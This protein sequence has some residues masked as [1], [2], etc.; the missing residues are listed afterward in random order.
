MRRL[1]GRE[2]TTL[3][4]LEPELR[5][6]WVDALVATGGSQC[7]FCTPGILLRLAA[8]TSTPEQALLAHLCRCTGWQTITE[9]AALVADGTPTPAAA[10]DVE[11]AS[12]R[13]ELE[14][15][16]AQRVGP[17]VVCGRGGFA[18]DG[19]PADAYVAVPRA[20]G[21][22]AVGATLAEARQAA[23]KVQ[24]RSTTLQ[25]EPPL[26]V[27]EGPWVATLATSWVEPAYL[28]PDASWCV[29]GGEPASPVG[30]GG[31]FGAKMATPVAE[32][33]RALADEYG[34]PV[35]VVWAREDVVRLGHK[36][37]PVAGGIAADGTGLLLVGWSGPPPEPA[38]WAAMESL[39]GAV[40]PGLV[41]ERV[42]ILGPPTSLRLRATV[43][44]EAA[45]LAGALG[46]EQG[47]CVVALPAR[48]QA[49]VTLD[50]ESVRVRVRAGAELDATV[51]RSYVI[52]A[53]HQGLGW[54]RS[55]G[56]AVEDDGTVRDLTIR[57]YGILAA[58]AMPRVD[59]EIVDEPDRPPVAVSD[60]VYVATALAAWNEA[61]RPTSWPVDRGRR[62]AP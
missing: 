61:G 31:A 22:Y 55:E 37:P 39:V 17:E 43:V 12:R 50:G 4:G 21:G 20:S 62:V 30:N 45:V 15:G 56:I 7:G 5:D 60:S 41:L 48:G 33:A 23:G 36:R 53:V 46:P 26:A 27:P 13:A 28:E 38:E 42:S 18:D 3:D 24:G 54:V 44:A 10:R 25:P 34:R 52:G 51:L 2:I 8:A 47:A 11:G 6:R 14:G 59:V 49:E 58:R 16:I 35:R 1:D 9:A 57:S 32:D 19:A 29:P 40:A